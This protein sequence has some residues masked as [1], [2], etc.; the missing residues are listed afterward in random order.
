MKKFFALILTIVMLCS[1]AIVPAFATSNTNVLIDYDA[2]FV[3]TSGLAVDGGERSIIPGIALFAS[4]D[5]DLGTNGSIALSIANFTN[6][7]SR[8]S[9]YN[10]K[11]NSTKIKVTMKSDISISVR[12]TLYDYA[13]DAQ[14]AQD[15]VTVGTI[16]NTSITF[17]NLSYSKKYY[18]KWENLGQQQVNITGSISAT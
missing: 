9:D 1:I 18:I 2:P 17:T 16:F 14:V 10:Y 6:G 15:T 3:A 11:T 4:Q 7:S 12:V 13:T 8:Y 5:Y